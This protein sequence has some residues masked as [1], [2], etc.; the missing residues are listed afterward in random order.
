MADESQAPPLPPTGTIVTEAALYNAQIT[1]WRNTMAYGGQKNPTAIWSS[2]LRDDGLAI[3][4]YREI[5][6]KDTDVANALDSLR[7]AVLKRENWV[8]PADDSGLA[9]D[10]ANFVQAQLDGLPD[11]HSVLSNLLDAPGYGFALGEMIFDVSMGQAALLDIQDCPQELFLFGNRFQPQIGP[12]QFLTQ[13]QASEGAP[14]PEEKFLIFSY[15]M[16]SRN[17]MGRPLIR[18]VFWSSW[19][20]R[21]M[22]RLWVRYAE[23]G[24][25]TAAVRYNDGASLEEQQQAAELAYKLIDQ[26]AVGIPANFNF[27]AELLKGARPINVDVYEHFYEAVQLDIVRRILG[28]TL[29]S[30]GAEKGRGTQ[31]L[32]A[33]H[34][35][36]LDDRSV[37]LAKALA[38]IVNRQMVRPLVLWNF[39]PDAP[40]PSWTFD[41]EEEKDLTERL[42]IDKGLQTMGVPIPLSYAIETYGIPA[43]DGDEPVLQPSAAAGAF[44]LPTITPS[45]SESAARETGEA[46]LDQFDELTEQLKTAAE[47]LMQDRVREVADALGSAASR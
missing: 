31:A 5:E 45:F 36:S 29:T 40:M 17:R 24:P 20:K 22:Q 37:Q 4:Y 1:L 12:L 44:T 43:V 18:Q 46:Q 26:V 10:V 11:F 21:N 14:V 27:E 47:S 6:E 9:Q 3:P 41:I 39:G 35:E 16:R 2:M 19:F 28:E 8:Q 33:Q 42:A 25:G 23:K 13:V 38:G 32:G 34:A 7:D 15:R 30:F